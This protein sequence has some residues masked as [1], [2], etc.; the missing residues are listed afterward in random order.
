[1]LRMMGRHGPHGHRTFSELVFGQ[2]LMGAEVINEGYDEGEG[3][4]HEE[5]EN[6]QSRRSHELAS[7]CAYLEDD[8][9]EDW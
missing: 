5:D 4:G 9:I 7:S 8:D 2:D 6:S 3:V 1:V